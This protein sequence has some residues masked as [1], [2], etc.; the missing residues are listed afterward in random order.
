MNSRKKWFDH[1]RKAGEE[2]RSALADERSGGE[3]NLTLSA[4]FFNFVF[5]LKSPNVMKSNLNPKVSVL[6]PV[7]KTPE[8]YLRQAIESILGQTV[9]DFEFL[10]LVGS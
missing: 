2:R 1:K 9:D 5:T 7:Y 8:P 3:A 6:M 10:I 4:I